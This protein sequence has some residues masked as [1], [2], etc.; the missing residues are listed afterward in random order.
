MFISV[1][2]ASFL[3]K[4]YLHGG[5]QVL[6]LKSFLLT[7]Q[8]IPHYSGLV[9]TKA[10]LLQAHFSALHVVFIFFPKY[11]LACSPSL[12][13]QKH[14]ECLPNLEHSDFFDSFQ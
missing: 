3:E 11:E 13:P 14:L 7:S 5:L 4:L 2:F 8:Y 12:C 6:T 1:M 9:G 10:N